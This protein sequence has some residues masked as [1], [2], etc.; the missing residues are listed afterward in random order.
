MVK[1]KKKW[2]KQTLGELE[3]T[4]HLWGNGKNVRCKKKFNK[5]FSV[6][7]SN[8]GS[9]WAAQKKTF[10]WI[11]LQDKLFIFASVYTFILFHFFL[12]CLFGLF[13]R[14]DLLVCTW[15]SHFFL[16]SYLSRAH[17]KLRSRLNEELWEDFCGNAK[18]NMQFEVISLKTENNSLNFPCFRDE[19][20][21]T[22]R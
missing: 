8:R 17:S 6:S 1:Q 3:E 11:V 4:A 21:E 7:L 10:T 12:L 20:F 19:T 14:F 13:C 2:P 16:C 15:F 5:N 22:N 9:K 18:R